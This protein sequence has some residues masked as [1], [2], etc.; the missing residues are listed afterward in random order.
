[1]RYLLIAMLVSGCRVELPKEVA[2]TLSVSETASNN[3]AFLYDHLDVEF[4][5]C[6]YGSVVGSVIKVDTITLPIITYADENGVRFEHCV[7]KDYLGLGHSHLIGVQ[8]ELSEIDIRSFLA[9]KDRFYFLICKDHK[10][11][12]FEKRGDNEV[13]QRK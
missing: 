4:V 11:K 7:K 10:I 9:V 8:C 2:Y 6:N 12:V 1:M 13:S 5:F 3:L